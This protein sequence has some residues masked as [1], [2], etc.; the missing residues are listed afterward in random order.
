MT[1][2]FMLPR[3]TDSV[4]I[5][6]EQTYPI[7][8]TTK[9]MNMAMFQKIYKKKKKKCL[10]HGLGSLD[11]PTHLLSCSLDAQEFRKLHF[12]VHDKP[13]TL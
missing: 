9:G 2:S 7:T 13:D 6:L 1:G 5:I 12:V 11:P 8:K 4:V 10:A 3:T